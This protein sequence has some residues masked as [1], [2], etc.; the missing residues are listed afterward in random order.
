MKKLILALLTLIYFQTS[1]QVDFGEPELDENILNSKPYKRMINYS[2]NRNTTNNNSEWSK[3]EAWHTA[4]KHD[5]KSVLDEPWINYGPD[6]VSGR[7]IS[8]AFHPWDTNTMMVGSSSGG[9]WN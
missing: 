1:A 3:W 8:I 4:K 7:I 2:A 5:N 9:L 6:T